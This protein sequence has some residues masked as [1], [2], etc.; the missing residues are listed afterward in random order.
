[1][2]LYTLF[3]MCFI[4]STEE[5]LIST[6]EKRL[7]LARNLPPKC[8][9]NP[10]ARRLVLDKYCDLIRNYTENISFNWSV[11]QQEKNNSHVHAMTQK[12][13]EEL[14]QYMFPQ[15][16]FLASYRNLCSDKDAERWCFLT[17]N[18]LKSVMRYLEDVLRY[19]DSVSVACDTLYIKKFT[20]A[21]PW[22]KEP[23]NIAPLGFCGTHPK[24][25]AEK[26]SSTMDQ[27]P[28][29]LSILY[30]AI[31][32]LGLCSTHIIHGYSSDDSP[33]HS[34]IKLF[35]THGA[36]LIFQAYL[37]YVSFLCENISEEPESIVKPAFTYAS[38]ECK[39]NILKNLIHKIDPEHLKWISIISLSGKFF[40][41]T[42]QLV[43][44]WHILDHLGWRLQYETKAITESL[45][46]LGMHV[47]LRYCSNLNN[48][49]AILDLMSHFISPDI[50]S[51]DYWPLNTNSNT[52]QRLMH[53]ITQQGAPAF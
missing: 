50:A 9:P 22:L 25:F 40:I 18:E 48:A 32:F 52:Y 19:F 29:I 14:E 6:P 31:P 7:P 47:Y 42:I 34:L 36:A 2:I 45:A 35:L 15:E 13:Y 26:I 41:L 11:I 53:R 12:R 23:I 39:D 37:N 44:G 28:K 30:F 38:K 10:H 46:I 21:T 33:K 20:L 1:M 51:L 16:Y 24:N 27:S 8:A 43:N 17:K 5:N 4:L 49:W 3:L